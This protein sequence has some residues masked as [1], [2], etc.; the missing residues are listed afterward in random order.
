MI[1][2]QKGEENVLQQIGKLCGGRVSPVVSGARVL[3]DGSQRPAYEGHIMTINLTYL[4]PIIAYIEKHPLKTKK[5]L[6][7][8]K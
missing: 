7:Y 1:I 4:A 6:A 3:K 2:A 8:S 5:R